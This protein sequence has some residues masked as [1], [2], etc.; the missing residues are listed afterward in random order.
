METQDNDSL[1]GESFY[2]KKG[3]VRCVYTELDEFVISETGTLHL[4]N[5]IDLNDN[6]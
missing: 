2:D 4:I 6:K 1:I 5:E 3:E